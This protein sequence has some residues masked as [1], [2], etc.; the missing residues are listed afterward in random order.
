MMTFAMTGK[1]GIKEMIAKILMM[2]FIF[3]CGAIF[4]FF[5]IALAKASSDHELDVSQEEI[6]PVSA[7][8]AKDKIVEYTKRHDNCKTCIF[9]KECEKCW[10]CCPVEWGKTDE[11]P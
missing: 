9:E 2:F 6:S 7:R 3:F 5:I 4:G 11:I 1:V 10:K 8:R